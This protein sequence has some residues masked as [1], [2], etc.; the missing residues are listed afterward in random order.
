MAVTGS[1]SGPA[2]TQALTT[3]P[4]AGPNLEG[5][6]PPRLTLWV[7]RACWVWTSGLLAQLALR[8]RA[9][10]A[11]DGASPASIRLPV[12]KMPCPVYPRGD[13]LH[14]G[15]HGR[16]FP[17]PAPQHIRTGGA[18]G[19]EVLGESPVGK[20]PAAVGSSS[21]PRRRPSSTES[22]AVPPGPLAC[23][24][25]RQMREEC[26]VHPGMSPEKLSKLLGPLIPWPCSATVAATR[27]PTDMTGVAA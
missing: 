8:L 1:R 24:S 23:T 7:R 3:V 20:V 9:D 26:S 5:C 18:V 21:R 15:L 16:G 17:S 22:S 25:D 19:S 6:F 10:G 2:R 13:L 11:G 4:Q 14:S 27:S 12:A